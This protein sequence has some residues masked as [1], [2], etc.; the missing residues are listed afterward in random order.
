MKTGNIIDTNSLLSGS[1]ASVDRSIA[2]T[3]PVPTL[4]LATMAVTLLVVP[5][6]SRVLEKRA[7]KEPALYKLAWMLAFA[8]NVIAVSIPGR[9]DSKSAMSGKEGSIP[10]STLFEPAGW[11]FAIWGVIY[12]T[13]FLATT[14]V[15]LG[16]EPTEVYSRVTP[17]WVAG[18]LF[19]SAW[20]LA[21][22]PDLRGFLWIPMLLL[23]LS[24]ASL[25]L[26]HMVLTNSINALSSEFNADTQNI[27]RLVRLPFALHTGWLAAAT[28]L[29]MNAWAAV[30]NLSMGAQIAV[31][32]LSAYA[33]AGAGAAL[34]LRTRDATLAF[35]VAWALAAVSSRTQRKVVDLSKAQLVPGVAAEG[36]GMLPVH[37]ALA[38]TERILSFLLVVL[39]FG[40]IVPNSLF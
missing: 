18:N 21:F 7:T 5:V 35:T 30:S 27:L 10:W 31:A 23:A 12:L 37:A 22:R 38:V 6:L 15:G 24:G 25:G 16:N 39:G 9:F 8:V 17:Y 2:G 4:K 28:L 20:C 26:G 14:Y 29:T 36:T 33:A 13:E 34:T 11:A 19:Q 1:D 3:T 32:F 40:M